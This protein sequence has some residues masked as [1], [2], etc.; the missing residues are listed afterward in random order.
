MAEKKIPA[1]GIID[2]V[3]RNRLKYQCGFG[4]RGFT[5][6]ELIIVIFIMAVLALAV[7]PAYVTYLDRARLE[8]SSERLYLDLGDAYEMA[9]S[10]KDG[11]FFYGIQLFGSGFAGGASTE[12]GYKLLRFNSALITDPNFLINVTLVKSS[13]TADN[14]I[15][16]EGTSLERNIVYAQAAEGGEL[17][18]NNI[19]IF[20]GDFGFEGVPMYN[21]GAGAVITQLGTG[22]NEIVLRDSNTNIR[23]IIHINAATGKMTL[24]NDR[25]NADAGQ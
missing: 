23:R 4:K 22:N 8:G 1:F 7:I 2:P 11:R 25:P 21:S 9:L 12:W 14:P 6:L 16:S 18:P 20:R 24:I 3:L 13:R 15:M 5:F 19:I 17:V 10:N